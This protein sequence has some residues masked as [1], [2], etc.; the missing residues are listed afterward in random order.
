MVSKKLSI[1]DIIGNI[2]KQNIE[3][4]RALTEDERKEFIPFMVMQWLACTDNPIQIILLNEFVNNYVFELYKYPELLY[5]LLTVCTSGN[6]QRYTWKKPVKVTP[7]N[8]KAINVIKE[9]YEYS[10]RQAIKTFPFLTNENVV[11]LA[12]ALGY[13]KEQL[14]ELKKELKER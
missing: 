3:Y 7:T 10:T 8:T 13:Q 4:Y 12:N 11:V 14:T 5:Y 1:F 2:D 6:R 9:A